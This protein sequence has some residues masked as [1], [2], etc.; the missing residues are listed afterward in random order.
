[1]HWDDVESFTFN[2]KHDFIETFMIFQVAF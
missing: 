1:L 2:S